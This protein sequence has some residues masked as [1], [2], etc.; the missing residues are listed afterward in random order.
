MS[1]DVTFTRPAEQIRRPVNPAAMVG[2]DSD[3]LDD[4]G[5]EGLQDDDGFTDGDDELHWQNITHNLSGMALEAGFYEHLWRQEETD[6][7]R[8][9]DLIEPLTLGIQKMESDPERFK[10]FDAPNGWG[11]Y[12]Q[13]LPWLRELLEKCHEFPEAT[14]HTCR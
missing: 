10:Q 4:L 14:V 3:N 8:A 12:K 7:Q 11:T 6:V 5:Y 9:R 1:L 2:G 13:F